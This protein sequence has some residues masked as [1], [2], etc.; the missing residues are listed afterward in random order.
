MLRDGF[1]DYEYLYVLAGGQPQVDVANAADA[2]ADKMITGLTSYTRNSEF[3]YNLRRLIGLKNGGEIATIPDINPPPTH[4]RAEGAPGNYYINFQDPAGR[5][6]ANPLVVGGKT[7]MKIGAEDYSAT[8]GYGWYSPPE[9]H[10]MTTYLDSGP[11]VLQR[12]ILYSDYGRP[13]TF[14]FDLPNGAYD[15]TVSVGWQGRAYGHN[16]IDIEGQVFVNDEAASPYLVRTQRVAIHDNKLTMAM[17]IFDEYTMLNYLDIEAAG[18]TAAFVA[19][20][21]SG[22]TPL[23]VQFSDASQ[24]GPTA[25]EWDF[26]NDGTV[27][28][29]TQNASH[30]YTE[31]GVYSVRLRVSN[32]GG[33]DEEIKANHITTWLPAVNNLHITYAF[34][35]TDTL[36]AT[37]R[38]TPLTQAATTTLRYTHTLIT[39]ANWSA[40]TLINDSLPGDAGGMTAILPYTTTLSLPYNGGTY[41]FALKSQNAAGEWLGLSNNAFWPSISVYLPVILR[42]S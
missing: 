4:P 16:Y 11:N 38:W 3:A 20:V 8:A 27:D 31:P 6:T 25:W 9:A 10:W 30:T 13:A 19:N 5:P 28:A 14:E 7:Y 26:E 39:D 15:V 21:T 41:Y 37:L 12:S 36:V 17:G 29:T 2:Q 1:E 34:T 24:N 33:S 42:N 35:T 23:T 18:P 40:A 22:E 32:D